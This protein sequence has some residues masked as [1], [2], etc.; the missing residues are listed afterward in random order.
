MGP[1]L[2]PKIHVLAGAAEL[3]CSAV[4][5][6]AALSACSGPVYPDYDLEI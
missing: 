3:V 2:S 4:R 5:S 1:D 6:I